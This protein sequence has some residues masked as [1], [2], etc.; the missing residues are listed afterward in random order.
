[1]FDASGRYSDQFFFGNDYWLGS[2]TLCWDLINPEYHL[3]IPPFN[4]FFYMAKL[5]INI[6]KILTPV[7]SKK[8]SNVN[9]KFK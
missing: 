4:S 8:N 2:Y 1:M 3:D 5:R 6:N 7:V 9:E